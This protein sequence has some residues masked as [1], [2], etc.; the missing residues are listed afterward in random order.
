[1][2]VVPAGAGLVVTEE[3]ETDAPGIAYRG[4]RI[5]LRGNADSGGSKGAQGGNYDGGGLSKVHRHG[6]R[7][8]G[9]RQRQ[10]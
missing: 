4:L 8:W 5:E 2:A 10:V 7:D 3:T 1:M 6:I 9:G